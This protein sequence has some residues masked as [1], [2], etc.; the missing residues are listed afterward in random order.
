MGMRRLTWVALAVVVAAVMSGSALARG[1]HGLANTEWTLAD[2]GAITIKF[3]AEGRVS[4][5]GGCNSY[6]GDYTAHGKK[7]SFSPL[8]ST[9]RACADETATRQEQEYFKALQAATGFAIEGD[10]LKI[11]HPGGELDFVTADR[12]DR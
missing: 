7:L 4:G 5:S 2:N 6:G 11:M 3:S 1:G 10:H 12:A 9:K 8:I